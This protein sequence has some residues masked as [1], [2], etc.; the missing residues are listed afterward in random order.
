MQIFFVLFVLLLLF[1]KMYKCI[2]AMQKYNDNVTIWQII[3]LIDNISPQY[4]ETDFMPFRKPVA[5][6]RTENECQTPIFSLAP[7]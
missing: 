7:A 2:N 4:W 3:M 5:E 6:R 1:K